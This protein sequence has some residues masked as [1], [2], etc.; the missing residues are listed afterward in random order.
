MAHYF[1]DDSC[2]A[3]LEFAHLFNSDPVESSSD[4]QDWIEANINGSPPPDLW[5]GPAFTLPHLLKYLSINRDKKVVRE[6]LE[7][8]FK[9]LETELLLEPLPTDDNPRTLYR[10]ISDLGKDLLLEE[11][12]LEYIFGARVV[13]DKWKRSVVKIYHPTDAGIGTGFLVKPNLVAT[14][15]HVIEGMD[16]FEIALEDGI[17]ISPGDVRYP[18]KLE[19][20]DLALVEVDLSS[21]HDPPKPFPVSYHY[22]LLDEVVV[23]GYPPVPQSDDAYLVVNRGEVSSTVNR[24]DDLDAV[25]ISC[26]LQGGYSGGPVVNRRGQVIAVVSKNLFR[27]LPEGEQCLNEGLGYAAATPGYWLND[28]L[29]NLV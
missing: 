18:E 17:T 19:Y 3:V 1:D 9:K 28:F 14:A 29:N 6:R 7:R 2:G 21:L 8:I 20:L 26:L 22:E 11:S 24:I 5:E 4:R 23:F 12:Y 13:V 25:I 27:K 10:V 15:K 16:K